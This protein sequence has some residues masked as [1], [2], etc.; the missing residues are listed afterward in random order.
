MFSSSGGDCEDTE[1]SDVEDRDGVDDEDRDG[2]DD[3][4]RDGLR[5]VCL[6]VIQPLDAAGSLRIFY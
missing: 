1:G 2:V 6:L 4:E 3:E 5:N